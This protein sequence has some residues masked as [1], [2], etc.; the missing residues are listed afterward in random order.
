MEGIELQIKL[1]NID[2]TI[3]CRDVMKQV[4]NKKKCRNCKEVL[5]RQISAVPFKFE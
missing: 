5:V 2:Q 1:A 3:L 4:D